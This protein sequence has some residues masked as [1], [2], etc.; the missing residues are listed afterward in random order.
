MRLIDVLEYTVVIA[1]G[2]ILKASP[3]SHPRLFKS[4]NGGGGAFGIVVSVVF[5][6]GHCR[7]EQGRISTDRNRRSSS[8]R[9]HQWICRC[10]RRV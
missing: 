9:G 10:V 4:L 5:R 7:F 6:G 2:A 3:Y 8:S 1:T